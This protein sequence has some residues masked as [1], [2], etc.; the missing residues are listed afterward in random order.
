VGTDSLLACKPN[1]VVKSCY[2][3][4]DKNNTKSVEIYDTVVSKNRLK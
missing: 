1:T 2:A 3:V 4:K